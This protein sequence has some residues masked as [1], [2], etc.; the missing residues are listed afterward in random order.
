MFSEED[1]EE[2]VLSSDFMGGG[3]SWWRG[4]WVI[5]VMSDVRRVRVVGRGVGRGGIW[6]GL[7]YF[8]WVR[9]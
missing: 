5:D 3:E 2:E 8:I 7:F 1:E 6:V 9:E 4:I